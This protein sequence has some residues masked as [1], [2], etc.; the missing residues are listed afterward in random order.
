MSIRLQIMQALT[1]EL[2]AIAPPN[3]T[4]S[5]AGHVHRGKPAFGYEKQ[6]FAF[7]TML[8]PSDVLEILAADGFPDRR[9]GNWRLLLYGVT[10]GTSDYD[11]PTDTAYLLLADLQKCI[12]T[13]NKAARIAG[14]VPRP[15]GGLVT[16][17]IEQG[18][19]VVLPPDK[20]DSRPTAV[21]VL[22]LD[23]PLTEN[24][25]KL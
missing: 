10:A 18:R 21:C 2:A 8:E 11:N 20:D 6:S 15:L 7:V 16:G 19:G 12:A 5:L 9:A 3:Y 13:I 4:N 1:T 17:P 14:R 22:P 23:I 25:E 24:L